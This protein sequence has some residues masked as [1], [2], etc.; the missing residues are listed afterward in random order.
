MLQTQHRNGIRNEVKRTREVN[1]SGDDRKNR[2]SWR[3][4]IACELGTKKAKKYLQSFP[5]PKK[6]FVAFL[7]FASG[8]LKKAAQSFLMSDI[9]L[10]LIVACSNVRGV[11][12][13]CIMRHPHLR[14]FEISARHKHAG[15]HGRK[16]SGTCG[17]LPRGRF[18]YLT[19]PFIGHCYIALKT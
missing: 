7:G 17:V 18:F 9:R 1:D 13:R 11:S 6:K 19:P 3:A 16:S 4:K 8:F 10:G 5:R 12:C 15:L 14:A 2:I